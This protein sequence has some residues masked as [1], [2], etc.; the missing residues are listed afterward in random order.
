MGHYDDIFEAERV[1]EEKEAQSNRESINFLLIDRMNEI[2]D[3]LTRLNSSRDADGKEER[4]M[5]EQFNLFVEQVELWQ[6]K[7]K[8]K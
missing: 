2:Q 1:A 6:Y 4:R 8:L 7:R 5:Q 3:M